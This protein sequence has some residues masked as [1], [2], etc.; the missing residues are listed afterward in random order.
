DAFFSS[1][2][3]PNLRETLEVFRK[4]P[5]Y[6]RN[7]SVGDRDML[8]Y[9]LGTIGELDMPMQPSVFGE[10]AA[11]ALLTGAT[12]ERRARRRSEILNCTEADLK[13][14]A[15]LVQSVIDEDAFVTV[16]SE[17]KLNENRSLFYTVT[18]LSGE[19]A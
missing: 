9:I 11:N 2:R 5:E 12:Y 3:D 13:A 14:L 19:N 7:L 16:G 4:I 18:T 6:L 1:Y 8:K 10:T 17:S 15:A